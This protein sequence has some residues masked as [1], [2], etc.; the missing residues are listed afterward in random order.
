MSGL[1]SAVSEYMTRAVRSI[2]GDEQLVVAD[3]RMRELRVSCLLVLGALHTPIGVVSRTDLLRVGNASRPFQSAPASLSL[4]SLRVR[5]VMT[6][7]LVSIGLAESVAEAARRMVE[8]HLHRLFVRD[9]QELVGVI[10]T[11]DVMR[12]VLDARIAAPLARYMSSPVVTVDAASPIGD[13][14]ERLARAD[15]SGLIVTEGSVPIGLFTQVEALECRGLAA[16][17]PVETAMTQAML[18]LPVETQL[19]RAAGFTLSTR[20][21]R[22]LA[23]DHHHLR[24]VVTGLDFAR[25]AADHGARPTRTLAVTAR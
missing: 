3:A 24:G 23:I 22:V 4:P 19:F 20:A 2:G 16:S 18:A 12:A 21:R 13:A 10:S 17:T 5:E 11:K 8:Q 1:D 6:T 15:L 14:L 9:G 7:R 25:A